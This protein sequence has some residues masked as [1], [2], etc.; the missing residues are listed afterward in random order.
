MHIQKSVLTEPLQA[1]LVSSYIQPYCISSNSTDYSE[2]LLIFVLSVNFLMSQSCIHFQFSSSESKNTFHRYKVQCL[3]RGN[4]QSPS[5]DACN[6]H[7][8]LP[9]PKRDE[10]H[11]VTSHGCRL[12]SSIQLLTLSSALQASLKENLPSSVRMTLCCIR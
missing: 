10:V 6:T 8:C 11:E 2:D 9:Y 12:H 4:V 5:G 7:T 1:E 3:K